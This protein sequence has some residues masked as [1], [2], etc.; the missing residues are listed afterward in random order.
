[1]GGAYHRLSGAN[2]ALIDMFL[3][4]PDDALTLLRAAGVRYVATCFDAH[5]LESFTRLA[6]QGLAAALAREASPNWLREI[7]IASAPLRVYELR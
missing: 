5:T 4:P 6:P 7:S 2:R 1:L 3:A